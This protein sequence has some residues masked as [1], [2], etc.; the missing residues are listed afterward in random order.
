L[1]VGD[2]VFAANFSGRHMHREY[3]FGI[4]EHNEPSPAMNVR[5]NISLYAALATRHPTHRSRAQEL[6]LFVSDFE[7]RLQ[8][9]AN[10]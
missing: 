9:L 8:L 10:D 4:G 5:N 2:V 7:R 6:Q 1:F 3:L